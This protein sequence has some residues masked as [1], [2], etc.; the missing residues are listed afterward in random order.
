MVNYIIDELDTMNSEISQNNA[1]NTRI[2][3][4]KRLT[5]VKKEMDSVHQKFAD[6]QQKYNYIDLEQQVI[7][8]IEALSTIEAQIINN[9]I[10]VEFL[11]NKYGAGSYEVKEQLKNRRILEKRMKHYLDSG[12]GEL[13]IPLKN[14][15]RLGI[16]YS[17]H[18]RDVKVH[19]ML[20]AFLLQN[21]EQARL[22]EANNTPTVN[23]LEYARIPQKKAYPKRAIICLLIFFSGLILVSMTIFLMKWYKIQSHNNSESFVKL[24]TLFSHLKKW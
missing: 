13:I 6:F 18:Y 11:K 15:P 1:K 3:F 2:F 20:H 23:V 10:N 7:A 5:L 4:E 16:E 21:Y 12:S 14:A 19:E 8:S 24:T 22:S 17:Y 9:D